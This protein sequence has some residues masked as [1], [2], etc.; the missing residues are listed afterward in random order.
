M[1]ADVARSEAGERRACG[2]EEVGGERDGTGADSGSKGLAEE[3]RIG[4][5][6]L[7]FGECERRLEV[8]KGGGLDC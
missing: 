7:L 2:V 8:G 4:R 1:E 3:A 6:A 5:R